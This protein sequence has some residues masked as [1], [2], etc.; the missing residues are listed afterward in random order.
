M[1][2][3]T[4]LEQESVKEIDDENAIDW[5]HEDTHGSKLMRRKI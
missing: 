3:G 5:K 1:L 4:D 2:K